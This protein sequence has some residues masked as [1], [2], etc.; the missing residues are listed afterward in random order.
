LGF[1]LGFR[2]GI[3]FRIGIGIGLGIVLVDV[4]YLDIAT[5]RAG[6]HLYGLGVLETNLK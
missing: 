1:R 6:L 3:G 5:A 2:V 4:G